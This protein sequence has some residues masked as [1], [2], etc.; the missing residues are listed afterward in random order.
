MTFI[1]S[2]WRSVALSQRQ[3]VKHYSPTADLA[4][5]ERKY[6]PSECTGISNGQPYNALVSASYV[7]NIT[8][9][10]AGT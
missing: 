1:N 6:R 7:E 5:P 3:L 10:C 9:P 4:G 2:C 8:R